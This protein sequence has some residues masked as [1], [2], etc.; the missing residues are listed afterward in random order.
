MKVKSRTLTI[1]IA[2]LI[3]IGLWIVLADHAPSNTTDALVVTDNA[4]SDANDDAAVQA[5]DAPSDSADDKGAA[6]E[7]DEEEYVPK[8]ERELR[9]IL[10]RTQFEVTQMEGTE[11]A[12]RNR[13]WN[14]KQDG[15]YKCVVCE[16][17]LFGSKTKFKSGTGWPSFYAPVNKKNV[18]LRK[19]FHLFY[20]RTEV[21]CSRCNA[22]LG[23]VFD[24]G[25]KPTGKR[26][27]MNS[28]S[29]KFAK[30]PK[31]S[32]ESKVK[33]KQRE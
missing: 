16:L 23:H 21:H 4:P 30:K 13:Y 19:D 20:E 11:P 17:D 28:A 25:P 7:T 1:L 9:R 14:Y 26:Y 10:S 12:F 27:C 22:H 18:G 5:D 8:T 3:A 33:T 6:A 15:I 2:T 29:L 31:N 32:S 24:D